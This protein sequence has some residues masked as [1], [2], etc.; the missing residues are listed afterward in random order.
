MSFKA[1][2]ESIIR[3]NKLYKRMKVSISNKPVIPTRNK[4]RLVNQSRS[5]ITRHYDKSVISSKSQIVDK[6]SY[7]KNQVYITNIENSKN[8]RTLCISR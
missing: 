6:E 3:A 4:E 8:I 2:L 5:V 7:F 1:Y